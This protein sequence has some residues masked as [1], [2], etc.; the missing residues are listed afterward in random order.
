MANY[1][2][3][4]KDKRT[5]VPVNMFQKWVQEFL[6]ENEYITSE[7]IPENISAFNN[8]VGYVTYIPPF[9]VTS[10]NGQT[11]NVTLSLFSG[12]YADLTNKPVIPAAQVQSNWTATTGLGVILN[13]PT[14]PTALS[15]LTNDTSFITASSLKRQETFLGVTNASGNYTVT[16]TTPYS[17]VPDVQPQLQAGTPSQVVRI[18]SST[19]TG[20]TVQVT[21]RASVTLLAVEVLLAATTPVTGASVSVLVTAR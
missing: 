14:I 18:T 21:N 19:T 1:R 15:Q 8:D 20:F 17:S 6:I 4:S 3:P 9:P 10:V 16:Y 11:G 5:P 7:D 13:K 12:N 2:G